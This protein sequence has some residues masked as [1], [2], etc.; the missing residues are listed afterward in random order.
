MGDQSEAI[1]EI[2]AVLDFTTR[3]LGDFDRHIDHAQSAM[4]HLDT[5]QVV[6]KI[7]AE[8]ALLLLIAARVTSKNR[9]AAKVATIARL[10]APRARTARHLSMLAENPQA[11]VG[12]A[13]AHIALSKIGIGDCH[14]DRA[15]EMALVSPS[16][17]AVDRPNFRQMELKWLQ[18]CARG[19]DPDFS[20]LAVSS[21]VRHQIHPIRMR[22][23]D[24]YAATHAL[25]YMT[26]FGRRPLP[27]ELDVG[28]IA[29][30]VDHTLCWCLDEQDWDL[31]I[32][33]MICST[34]I[35]RTKTAAFRAADDHVEMLFA[36]Y[37]MVFGPNHQPGPACT[38]STLYDDAHAMLHAYHTTY[39]Y[40]ILR[41]VS[42]LPGIEYASV[43]FDSVDN[44]VM[45]NAEIIR[46]ARYGPYEALIDRLESDHSADNT[47]VAQSCEVAAEKMVQVVLAVTHE[48]STRS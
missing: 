28:N 23:E 18:G 38:R 20:S 6:D 43:P 42:A 35:G 25:F 4:P 24:G 34:I 33:V 15:V 30:F 8:T 10:L 41:A 39:V 48:A 3:L 47:L 26:D 19:I 31:L 22:R 14:F 44:V 11:V 40:G 27:A 7:I 37:G 36:R 29:Y 16:V 45:S 2:G 17:W 9:L 21:L 46:L 5:E 32:E 13:L 12:V 1:A